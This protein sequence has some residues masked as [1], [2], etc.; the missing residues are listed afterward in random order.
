MCCKFVYLSKSCLVAEG[1][2]G[3]KPLDSH[4]NIGQCGLLKQTVD[5]GNVQVKL[6]T[7]V[8]IIYINTVT[9]ISLTDDRAT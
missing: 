4:S 6:M 8:I 9:L 2:S 5:L 3:V 1:R 7:A